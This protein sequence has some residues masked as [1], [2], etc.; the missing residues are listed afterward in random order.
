MTRAHRLLFPTRHWLRGAPA[1]V[2]P[3]SDRRPTTA[4]DPAQQTEQAE[5][6]QPVLQLR[7]SARLEIG[8][9]VVLA[10]VVAPVVLAAE[11]HNA[12]GVVAAAERAR[13]HVGRVHRPLATHQACQ[14]G[15]LVALRLRR[16]AERDGPVSA[17]PAGPSAPAG[18]GARAACS[19]AGVLYAARRAPASP[20]REPD[21]LAVSDRVC[22]WS[23]TAGTRST[24][25]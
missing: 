2:G 25:R 4:R 20:I 14:V 13:H 5:V 19:G 12:V 22:P 21:P 1:F 15:N 24:S 10:T 3:L 8:Q 23:I 17:G 16:G 6:A 18:C 11:R 9:Q 7:T